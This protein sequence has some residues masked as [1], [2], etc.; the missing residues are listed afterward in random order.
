MSALSRGLSQ[1]EDVE[2]QAA[3][4][5]RCFWPSAVLPL[6]PQWFDA[7]P[8]PRTVTGWPRVTGCT[9]VQRRAGD[10][11]L[12][13]VPHCARPAPL[14][15]ERRGLL[16][17]A[18]GANGTGATTPGARFDPVRLLSVAALPD[19]DGPSAVLAIPGRLRYPRAVEARG[20]FL[21]QV[22]RLP[23][24]DLYITGHVLRC[25]VLLE[26]AGCGRTRPFWRA[27]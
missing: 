12:F 10:A 6:R 27:R 23:Q 18:G 16:L 5:P 1:G 8:A 14:E 17:G 2:A 13:C 22:L 25:Q 9:Q 20:L 15:E 26:A 19:L 24:S 21:G 4:K 11:K 7:R 3:S